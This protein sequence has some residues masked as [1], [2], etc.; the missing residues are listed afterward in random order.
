MRGRRYR[1]YGGC[2]CCCGKHYIDRAYEKRLWRKE[3]ADIFDDNNQ[4][5]VRFEGD[6]YEYANFSNNGKEYV[7][8]WLENFVLV[9]EVGEEITQSESYSAMYFQIDDYILSEPYIIVSV[10]SIELDQKIIDDLKVYNPFSS[11]QELI[12]YFMDVLK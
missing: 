5:C 1:S 4:W 12:E 10:Y 7:A 8:V 2:N 6:K 3:V 11:L 9:I